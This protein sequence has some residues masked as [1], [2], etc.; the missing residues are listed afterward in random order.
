MGDMYKT[1]FSLLLEYVPQIIPNTL[2]PKHICRVDIKGDPL[3]PLTSSLLVMVPES[4]A[5]FRRKLNFLT[6]T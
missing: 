3:E 1:V 5:K 4:G 2:K 6:F